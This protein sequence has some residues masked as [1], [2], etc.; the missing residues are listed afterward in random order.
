MVANSFNVYRAHLHLY[1]PAGAQLLL[2]ERISSLEA[3][4]ARLRARRPA[5]QRAG[6]GARRAEAA[7]G[8]GSEKWIMPAPILAEGAFRERERQHEREERAAKAAAAAAAAAAAEVA[9]AAEV[10]AAEVAGAAEDPATG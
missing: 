6:G 3:E 8:Q 2:A 10:A 4:R 9:G 1:G 7:E 5:R